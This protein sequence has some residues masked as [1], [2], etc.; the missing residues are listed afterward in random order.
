[1]EQITADVGIGNKKGKCWKISATLAAS[2][3]REELKFRVQIR[4]GQNWE[5]SG[6]API[7]NTN[8]NTGSTAVCRNKNRIA[9]IETAVPAQGIDWDFLT[10]AQILSCTLPVIPHC[11]L[12]LLKV[13]GNKAMGLE[14][15][16]S[17][18]ISH[19]SVTEG[20]VIR[21]GAVTW[22]RFPVTE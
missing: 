14:M 9:N 3:R 12:F 21:I 11:D 7:E 8:G 17:L 10:E 15:I 16:N 20:L 18:Q 1:M 5:R 4:L 19:I 2:V 13:I 6:V 22:F